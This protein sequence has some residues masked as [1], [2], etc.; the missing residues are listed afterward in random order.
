MEGP[1]APPPGDSETGRSH[2]PVGRPADRQ[3]RRVVRR[4]QRSDGKSRRRRVPHL[5]RL[6]RLGLYQQGGD[7]LPAGALREGG[8]GPDPR[9]AASLPLEGLLVAQRHPDDPPRRQVRLPRL[10][11]KRGRALRPGRRAHQR[12]RHRSRLRAPAPTP[13]R[14]GA[15][16]KDRHPPHAGNRR[17]ALWPPRRD[18][19]ARRR[20]GIRPDK[21]PLLRRL[22]RRGQVHAG[23]QVAGADGRGQ[24]SRRA[25]R[26]RLVLLQ[27]GHRRARHLRRSVHRHRPRLVRRPRPH[28]GLT[29]GQ[30]AAAGRAGA[31]RENAAGARRHGAAAVLSRLRARQGDRPRPGHA[32]GRAGAREPWPVP[33]HHPRARGRPGPLPRHDPGKEPG[34]DLRRGRAR[35]AARGWGAGHGRGDGAG[36]ARFRQPR[37]GAEPAG[38]PSRPPPESPTC[39]T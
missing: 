22:G 37:P 20:L 8:D 10:Q 27:P 5:R 31:P 1:P 15:A 29:L 19:A 38:T 24:L 28:A 6:S 34:A 39:P 33:D 12:D 9:A 17:E 23:Q 25:P 26:L 36:H 2:R 16:G 18:G 14:L 11:G 32:A 21:H 7:P 30:G 35:A 13:A 4:N 3:R